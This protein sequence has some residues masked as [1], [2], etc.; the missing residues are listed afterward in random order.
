[1]NRAGLG[2]LVSMFTAPA[3]W[4]PGPT[5]S[6]W[7]TATRRPPSSTR[8]RPRRAALR[9]RPPALAADDPGAV[10][11]LAEILDPQRHLDGRR[12]R[13]RALLRDGAHGQP[14]AR[15]GGRAPRLGHRPARREGRGR[16]RSSPRSPGAASAHDRRARDEAAVPRG[17]GDA[18]SAS[19]APSTRSTP[20]ARW[21]RS[22]GPTTPRSSSAGTPNRAAV[23]DPA[24]GR[25]FDAAGPGAD[26]ARPRPPGR[27]D[28]RGRGARSASPSST[29]RSSRRQRAGRSPTAT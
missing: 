23:D 9:R 20:A 21:P 17:G 19:T 26:A 18:S 2:D 29:R 28:G 4:L 1:M 15:D 10:G 13:H 3:D 7:T 27:G 16:R 8:P 25:K 22:A 11:R 24:A 12:R 6:G 5:W 14:P